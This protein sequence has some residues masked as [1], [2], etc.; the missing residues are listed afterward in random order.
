M[1][2]RAWRPL[3]PALIDAAERGRIPDA[4]LRFGVRR[5]V[6]DRAARIRRDGPSETQRFVAGLAGEPIARVP[7]HANRQHY[8]V[9]VAFFQ[10][11]L[12]PHMK[13]SG[14]LYEPGV[15]DLEGAE[16]AMLEQTIERAGVEDGMRVL[17]LGCGWGSFSLF[18]AERLPGCRVTAVSNSKLQ[19]EHILARARERNLDLTVLTADMNGFDPGGRFDR[20][21]SIEMFEHM[22][23]WPRL[24]ARIGSWLE[25]GGCLFVH[26]FCHARAAYPYEIRDE[27]DWMARY[28]FTGGMMPSEDLLSRF[29]DDLHVEARWRVD[30]THYQRTANDW[31]VRMDESRD[32]LLPVFRKTYGADAERWIGRWRLFFM[33]CAELFGYAGGAEWFVTHQ[34]LAPTESASDA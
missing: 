9:P 16:R 29:H 25:P 1:L 33:G 12:G 4:L 6:A 18:C 19:R 34:R 13:Y 26:H 5:M 21:V 7:D 10:H 11:V 28:F 24:L 32:A 22:R 30:G 14:C 17:D 3:L 23:N 31:L 8:E 27:G 2:E 15:R 20:I